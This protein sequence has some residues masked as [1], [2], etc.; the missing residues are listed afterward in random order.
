MNRESFLKSVN[1]F[2]SAGL[3]LVKTEN[4][5]PVQTNWSALSAFTTN[6]NSIS[7]S[8]EAGFVIQAGVVVIDEDPR[9]FIDG[10]DEKALLELSSGVKLSEVCNFIVKTPSGGHHYYFKADIDKLFPSVIPGYGGIEIKRKGNQVV[11]PGS[12]LPGGKEYTMLTEL[13]NLMCLN[14]LPASIESIL[15]PKTR[16]LESLNREYSDSEAD[17]QLAIKY[18]T[19]AKPAVEGELGDLT[20]FTT[21]CYGRDLGLREDVYLDLMLKHW[22][23]RCSP[24]WSESELCTKVG[25][26]YKYGGFDFGEASIGNPKGGIKTSFTPKFYLSDKGKIK[27]ISANA[28]IAIDS[29]P[30]T[31]GK[32]CY[33]SFFEG[34]RWFELPEWR[35][36]GS[37]S[38][39]IIDEDLAR[40]KTE[41]CEANGFN[42]TTSMISESLVLVARKNTFNSVK[43]RFDKLPKWDGVVRI[44]TFFADYC[45]ASHNAYVAMVAQIIFVGIIKRALE[46][47]CKFDY[48]PVLIGKQGIHKSDL[49]RAFSLEKEWFL[50]NLRVVFGSSEVAKHTQ[51]KL[52]A[53]WPELDNLSR[54]QVES[55]KAFLSTEADS[56]RHVYD[57]H[58]TTI[59]RTFV[60]IG[61]TNK[62]LFL[63]DE[64][65][66]RR[67]LPVHVHDINIEKARKDM[68][69]IYAEAY[70]LYNSGAVAY[71]DNECTEVATLAKQA[72]S[73]SYMLDDWSE[74][75]ESYI[76]GLPETQKGTNHALAPSR[77]RFTISDILTGPLG[78]SINYKKADS[79]RVAEILRRLGYVSRSG[80]R[81]TARVLFYGLEGFKNSENS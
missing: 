71:I 26:A 18:L 44:P 3:P 14:A 62:V 37:S 20:T 73:A 46:P 77:N 21:C 58:P 5:V 9:N 13:D 38:S 40:I 28:V 34:V 23:P 10:V 42:P 27:H 16:K 54:L 25:N 41:I 31:S 56:V 72:Q 60:P 64:T 65:G 48:L 67:F 30:L 79:N 55:V 24:P 57:R 63:R 4:K 15:N 74:L 52:V 68:E 43:F 78:F 6:W 59:R 35:K 80:I 75:V 8:T 50:S 7:S 51:G 2:K 12:I 66:N 1:L 29:H 47:G 19:H 70:I 36:G 76:H 49:V 53:E 81:G 22:N 39:L 33:D 45:N 17:K 11:I 32:L 69:Q 61:T